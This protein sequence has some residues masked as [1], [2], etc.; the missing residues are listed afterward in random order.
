[1]R[2]GYDLL[3]K[4]GLKGELEIHG[5]VASAERA[6]AAAENSLCS[7]ADLGGNTAPCMGLSVVLKNSRGL[8]E[9]VLK[10]L[11]QSRTLTSLSCGKRIANIVPTE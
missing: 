10:V 7:N 2:N 1:M 11:N 4:Q 9:S 8:N 3:A 6:T 5:A